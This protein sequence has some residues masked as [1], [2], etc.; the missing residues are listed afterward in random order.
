MTGAVAAGPLTAAAAWRSCERLLSGTG[1]PPRWEVFNLRNITSPCSFEDGVLVPFVFGP[2]LPVSE[3]DADAFND[4]FSD[5]LDS[6]FTSSIGC[7]DFCYADFQEKWPDVSFRR[8]GGDM[9]SIDALWAVDEARLA[10]AW[11]PL[12]YS[13]LRRLVRCPRCQRYGPANIYLFEHRISDVEAMEEDIATLSALGAATPFLILEHPFAQTVLAEIRAEALRVS[14]SVQDRPMYRARRTLDVAKQ[15]QDP[16]TPATYGPAPAPHT[17]EGRF[18]HAGAPMLYLANSE[19]VAAAELGVP[20][21][22]CLVG[23]VTILPPLKI[24]DLIDADGDAVDSELFNALANSALL[25]APRTGE[26]W[27]K[28]QYLFSRFVADCA[29]SAGFDAIRY[30]ST[31]DR[32]GVNYVILSPPEDLATLMRLDGVSQIACPDPAPRY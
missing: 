10:G 16:T 11:W 28:R 24:L 4:A 22:D 21:E 19:A 2:F 25:M 30:G 32:N 20:G 13:T 15:G 5:E 7:C 23:R 1:S 31:K 6:A 3:Q 9:L 29:R 17:G 18:N 12:E 27:V 14:A 26:G 8:D